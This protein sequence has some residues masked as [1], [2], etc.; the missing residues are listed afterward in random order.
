MAIF[1]ALHGTW[2]LTQI[3]T[4]ASK[5]DS[6]PESEGG[7]QVEQRTT[8]TATFHP[9]YPTL[10]G[11]EREYLYEEEVGDN[12]HVQKVYRFADTGI[13]QAHG[14]AGR[15]GCL[16]LSYIWV[17]VV[18][19]ERDS[20]GGGRATAGDSH[21]LGVVSVKRL[22]RDGQPMPGKYVVTAA[23]ADGECRYEYVFR[24]EGVAIVSWT[25]TAV[26]EGVCQRVMMYRRG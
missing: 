25:E 17:S 18:G 15:S 19:T 24:F 21:G 7:D 4:T 5:S 2:T 26:R 16:W 13:Q 9:R 8:G 3:T 6:G 12:Q 1:R 14:H 23:G 11:Y 20:R 10:P 22:Y